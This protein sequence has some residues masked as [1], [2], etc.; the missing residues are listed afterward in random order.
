M[1]RKIDSFGEDIT[2]DSAQSG[3]SN[4]AIVISADSGSQIDLPDAGF[5]GNAE[6]LRDGHDLILETETGETVIIEGYFLASPPPLLID[7]GGMALTPDLVH[8][9]AENIGPVQYASSNAGTL[10]DESPVGAVQEVSGEATVTRTDGTV[11]TVTLGTPIYQGDIVETMGDGA[12]NIMFIDES[13]F[14]VSEDARL[15]IDEYVFDPSAMSGV[16]NVSVLRGVFV[17]TSGLIGREDPDDVEIETPVGSI[18]IRGTT[19]AGKISEDGDSQITV[20]EGAI[21]VRNAFGEQTLSGQFET[22]GLRSFNEPMQNMGQL[23]S[24]MLNQAYGAARGVAADTFLAIDAATNNNT[25]D[26][27]GESGDNANAAGESGNE[28]AATGATEGGAAGNADAQGEASGDGAS[29]AG[30]EEPAADANAEEGSEATGDSAAGDES[31]QQESN[32]DVNAEGTGDSFSE[33]GTFGDDGSFG[34]LEATAGNLV[35]GTATITTRT[36]TAETTDTLSKTETSGDTALSPTLISNFRPLVLET[37]AL[38]GLSED[39]VAGDVIAAFRTTESFPGAS[40]TVTVNGTNIDPSW[41]TIES[42]SLRARVRLSA[43]G[44]DAL[45][46][47]TFDAGDIFDIDVT[48]TLQSGR[49]TSTAISVTVA[50]DGVA[51]ITP[52]AL[53]DLA[54]DTVNTNL[55]DGDDK[56]YDI[57]SAI[58]NH[59]GQDVLSFGA[60]AF[61]YTKYS[62]H[63]KDSGGSNYY[64]D[65]LVYLG[66]VDGDNVEDYLSVTS[67]ALYINVNGTTHQIFDGGVDG[68]NPMSVIGDINGDGYNDFIIGVPNNDDGSSLDVGGSYVLFGRP[69]FGA[70]IDLDPLSST[71]GFNISFDNDSWDNKDMMGATVSQAGDFNNDGFSDFMFTELQ[72]GNTSYGRVHIGFGENGISGI[73]A[74][75]DS[76]NVG[77]MVI[78]GI[79]SHDSDDN[80]SVDDLPIF[81]GGDMNGDGISDI[82]I[83]D[84]GTDLDADWLH[85]IY[86]DNSRAG[87]TNINAADGIDAAE[88]GFTLKFGTGKELIGGNMVGDFNGDGRDDFVMALR[89]GDYVDVF[90]LFG[91]EGMEGTITLTQNDMKN[92]HDAGE[93]FLMGYDLSTLT[94]GKDWANPANDFRMEFSTA[95]D[96]DGDGF[97]DIVIGTPDW[98]DATNTGAGQV[99]VVY[100][101]N[102]TGTGADGDDVIINSNP[103]A[104][105][106]GQHL[107]GDANNMNF[108]ANGYINVSM[109]GGAG[110]DHFELHGHN[111]DESNL[112][113]IDGGSG[114]DRLHLHDTG[115][116]LDFTNVG[117]EGISGIEEIDIGNSGTNTL[118]LGIDDIFRLMQESDL[119]DGGRQILKISGNGILKID[120]NNNSPELLNAVNELSTNHGFTIEGASD[121]NGNGYY[122]MEF[123]TGYT[124][125]IDRDIT[126]TTNAAV[127]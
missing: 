22:V 15:A 71:D 114:I 83:A 49:S 87:G 32:L 10:T 118:K 31:A 99:L 95:G 61:A 75:G 64:K 29:E 14:A 35:T 53:H 38:N 51:N 34:N 36:Q 8:S 30:G 60:N 44:A 39:S 102:E 88:N 122:D 107:V 89:D 70:D 27:G 48:V 62:S 121:T 20:V 33:N 47:G 67:M 94:D 127:I 91:S 100:G 112:G 18:G 124:L 11:E 56:V 74:S 77:T 17:F 6:I 104:T 123:G 90:V 108:S 25:P 111:F 42:G 24:T 58:D 65:N 16:Q 50:D 78:S 76:G 43:D 80:G 12:V 52:L 1:A 101:R 81:G 3:A 13:S 57:G 55:G 113:N 28:G 86:G 19:I 84:L 45:S 119:V 85:V 106:D 68:S 73:T 79:R 54:N 96:Q 120:N 126:D 26:N 103:L 23:D 4:E 59:L 2:L 63:Y 109:R 46:A 9:F 5:L 92:M 82:G 125:L 40:Y 97:D 116:T 98:G 93:G 66:D 41:F 72:A 115:K 105:A 117:S 69:T 37:V 110:N 21:V 7:G